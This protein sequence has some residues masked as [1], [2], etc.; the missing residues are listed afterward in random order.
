MSWFVINWVKWVIMKVNGILK[1]SSGQDKILFFL[2][3]FP[4]FADKYFIQAYNNF[5]S[6]N[7]TFNPIV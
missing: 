2:K 4:L 1:W 5:I 6:K 3:L 7:F